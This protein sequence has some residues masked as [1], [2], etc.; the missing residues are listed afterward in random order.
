[1]VHTKADQHPGLL[2]RDNTSNYTEN[3]LIILKDKL[4]Q[5]NTNSPTKKIKNI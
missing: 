3:I 2:Y 5:T 1:M 4:T